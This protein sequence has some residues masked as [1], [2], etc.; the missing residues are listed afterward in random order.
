VAEH[1]WRWLGGRNPYRRTAFQVLDLGPEVHGRGSIQRQVERRRARIRNAP[2]RHRL[3]GE[4]LTEAE[5]NQAAQVLQD[6]EAWLYAELCTHQ[7]HDVE[8]DTGAAEALAKR[9]AELAVPEIEAGVAL[10]R[11]R[12]LAVLPPLGQEALPPVAPWLD[13]DDKEEQ[14][15]PGRRD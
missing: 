5:V 6:P 7:C 15:E 13:D 3:F 11:A 8:L 2:G 12:L 10:D 1:P 14:D 4:E 9:L